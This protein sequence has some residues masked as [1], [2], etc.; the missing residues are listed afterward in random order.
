MDITVVP[1]DEI[2]QHRK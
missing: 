1:D 2:M